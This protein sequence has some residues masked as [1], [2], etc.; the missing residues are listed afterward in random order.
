MIEVFTLGVQGSFDTPTALTQLLRHQVN[1]VL[2]CICLRIA[3]CQVGLDVEDK[4]ECLLVVLLRRAAIRQQ[5][6]ALQP[7]GGPVEVG[8][9]LRA[10]RVRQPSLEHSPCSRSVEK[11]ALDSTV[12]R[13]RQVAGFLN[14]LTEHGRGVL[15]GGLDDRVQVCPILVR[16]EVTLL[17]VRLVLRLVLDAGLLSASVVPVRMR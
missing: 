16:D 13:Q 7:L 3:L 9:V 8:V 10:L 1:E 4:R 5:R 11:A 12:G 2:S 17:V 15:G 14:L 6:L